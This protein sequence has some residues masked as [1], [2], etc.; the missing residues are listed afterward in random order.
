MVNAQSKWLLRDAYQ[1]LGGHGFALGKIYPTYVDFR[2]YDVA[3][4]EDLRGPN[5]LAVR[6]DRA[7]LIDLLA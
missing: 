1:L 6:R 5:Y 4:D 2:D 3:R 7:D